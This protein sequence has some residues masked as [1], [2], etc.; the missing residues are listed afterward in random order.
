MTT[1]TR[2]ATAS[3][4]EKPETRQKHVIDKLRTWA[5]N[6]TIDPRRKLSE[7]SLAEALGVS[8]TP[9]RHALAVLVEEGV[10]QRVGARGYRVRAYK[11]ADVIEAIELRSMIEGY[12]AKKIASDG[13]SP[14]LLAALKQCLAEG[15]DIFENGGMDDPVNEE[16]YA[17]MNLR[18]HTLIIE[19]AGGSLLHQ[20]T[21]LFDRVPFGAPDSIRFDNIGRKD[22]EQH[23]HY[24]HWQHHHMV[25]AL[26]AR[27]GA[28]A[29]N[30]F[31]E[32]GEGVKISLG[33]SK[34]LFAIDGSRILPIVDPD[35]PAGQINAPIKDEA[36][37]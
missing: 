1:G 18:F 30:L 2:S 35:S 14:E 21:S 22:R 34:G 37:D 9:I 26:I 29:E 11:V 33:I 15:D 16:R 3:G 8:R 31:R 4:S 27:D 12:A 25:S 10:L 36:D 24:A 28:R 6:G 13:P 17:A 20:L 32:H 7:S 23:L 19:A 5:S